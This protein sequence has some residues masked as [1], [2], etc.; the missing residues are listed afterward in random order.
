MFIIFCLLKI[1]ID[2]GTILCFSIQMFSVSLFLI[3]IIFKS[4]FDL[5]QCAQRFTTVIA[6]LYS[7]IAPS[8][9]LLF[10]KIKIS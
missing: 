3:F 6:S 7:F 9:L 1:A 10:I 4:L 2:K 8:I 5:S